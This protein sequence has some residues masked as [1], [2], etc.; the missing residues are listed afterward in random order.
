MF[1][2]EFIS[3]NKPTVFY[4]FGFS[5]AAAVKKGNEVMLNFFEMLKLQPLV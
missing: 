1:L 3:E 5:V 2:G 4:I